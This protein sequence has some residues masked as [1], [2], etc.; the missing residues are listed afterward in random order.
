MQM[1]KKPIRTAYVEM[2]SPEA[3][4]DAIASLDLDGRKISTLWDGSVDGDIT[5]EASELRVES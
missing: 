1:K 5:P 4:P 2:G 3:T